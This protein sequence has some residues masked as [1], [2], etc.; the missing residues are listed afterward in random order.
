ML[1]TSSTIPKNHRWLDPSTSCLRGFYVSSSN[2]KRPSTKL[3]K[4]QE[5]VRSQG[6]AKKSTVRSSRET[7]YDPAQIRKSDDLKEIARQRQ[8]L[9]EKNKNTS[10]ETSL[11]SALSRDKPNISTVALE[12]DLEHLESRSDGSGTQKRRAQKAGNG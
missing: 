7:A 2:K 1:A 4:I 6:L 9:R 3:A 5:E 10:A 8:L 11:L 12:F